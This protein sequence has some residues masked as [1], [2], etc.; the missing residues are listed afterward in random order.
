[1]SD[2]HL[3]VI[4]NGGPVCTING[5]IE[6]HIGLARIVKNGAVGQLVGFENCPMLSGTIF[7]LENAFCG[8]P[9]SGRVTVPAEQNGI[10]L[11]LDSH[12]QASVRTC[13][14]AMEEGEGNSA[15]HQRQHTCQQPRSSR[16]SNYYAHVFLR[17]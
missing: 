15:S 14:T 1:M 6:I 3:Q 11:H 7:D 17:T 9:Y 2:R 13:E 4:G 12:S 5:E 8:G 10:P 16:R